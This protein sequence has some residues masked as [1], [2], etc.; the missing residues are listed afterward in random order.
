[1]LAWLVLVV[2]PLETVLFWLLFVTPLGEALLG[3]GKYLLWLLF[4]PPLD[5]GG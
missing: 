5:L 4:H 1:M 3:W 2:I